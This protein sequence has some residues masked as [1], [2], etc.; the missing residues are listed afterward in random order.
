VSYLS[1]VV[2]IIAIIKY[3]LYSVNYCKF[4]LLFERAYIFIRAAEL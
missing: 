3:K 2:D 4:F 1:I